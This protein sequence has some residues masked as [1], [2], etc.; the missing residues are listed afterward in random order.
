MEYTKTLNFSKE[1]RPMRRLYFGIERWFLGAYLDRTEDVFEKSKIKLIY[2][3][4]LLSVLSI[5]VSL[6]SVFQMQKV[7]FS[8][9]FV[10]MGFLLAIPFLLKLTKSVRFTS[11]LVLTLAFF[12]LVNIYFLLNRPDPMGIGAWFIAIIIIACFTLG[13]R[14]GFL[15]LALSVIAVIVMVNFQLND[16][17]L[18]YTEYNFNPME[19][20]NVL[21]AT[22]I[23]A[24]IPVV[25]IFLIILEFLSSKNGADQKMR[26]MMA[27][28]K[29][30]NAQLSKSE[31]KYRKFIEDADDLIYMLDGFGNFTYVNPAFEKVGGYKLDELED[32]NFNFFVKDDFKP[33]LHEA[34]YKQVKEQKELEYYEF[35]VISKGEEEVWIGQKVNMVFKGK[36]MVRAICIGRD[37]TKRK[38]V[39][40]QLIKAKEEAIEASEA[41]ADFL[42]S[43]SHEIRT[44]MNA[45]IGMTHLL[46]QENPRED[47][48][49]NLNTLKFSGENLLTIIND[50]LDFSKIE[51]GKLHLEYT[52]FSLK[53][54]MD[55]IYHSLSTKAVDK[56]IKLLKKYDESIPDFVIGDSVRLYQILNNLIGNAIKF[57]KEGHVII[58]SSLRKIE[59]E[60]VVVDFSIIDSGIGIPEDKIG[61]IFENFTQASSSTT[62]QFGGTGLGLAITKKLLE[63]QGSTIK[64]SSVFG[65]GSHFYFTLRFKKSEE[66]VDENKV[67]EKKGNTEAEKDLQDVNIL[68]VEDNRVNQ[69]VAK[70]FIS[71]WGANMD[72]AENGVEAIEAVQNKDYDVVLMDLQ[73]PVMGGLEATEKIRELGGEYVHLPI[74][75]LTASAVLEIQDE[76]IQAGMNDFLTKPFDPQMLL[77]KLKAHAHTEGTKKILL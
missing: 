45:V 55:S 75:A 31:A 64:V 42:S 44:P 35:P 72:I 40:H 37:I 2:K 23:R 54:V 66:K 1:F 46:L 52:S 9:A 17:S 58:Q 62:R 34:L 41:K 4:S 27:E 76:A 15:Y 70:K 16:Y 22:P 63:L 26:D 7:A 33:Q 56:N 51:S 19:N 71:K 8:I 30:L 57:T 24:F 50:I 25:I 39:E 47:Q 38:E 28:Q 12:N 65:K 67:L 43:M 18:Y 5:L 68:L 53:Y 14:W 74:I 69:L 10:T 20:A 61:L 3:F 21:A 49:E 48:V 32:M 36:M 29:E 6:P 73:M 59:G 11:K 77:T 60:E 13:R